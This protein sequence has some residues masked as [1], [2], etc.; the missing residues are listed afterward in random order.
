MHK[1]KFTINALAF[2]SFSLA[3]ASVAHAIPR[4]YVT[5]SGNDNNT[6]A[7]NAPC[8]TF[9]EAITKTDSGGE[10]IPLETGTYGLLTID[11]P[12]SIIAPPGVHAEIAPSGALTGIIVQGGAALG[13]VVLRNLYLTGTPNVGKGIDAKAVGALHVENCVIHGFDKGINFAPAPGLLYV[14]DTTVRNSH[15]GIYVVSTGGDNDN[16]VK[17][18][19]EHCRFENYFQGVVA[20]DRYGSFTIRDSIFT[21]RGRDSAVTYGGIIAAPNPGGSTSIMVE[22]CLLSN[23]HLAIGTKTDG[24]TFFYLSQNVIYD[25]QYGIS[26]CCLSKLNTFGN[27]RFEHND[28]DGFFNDSTALK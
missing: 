18:F 27:N 9:K 22:N 7:F 21:G 25:N 20:A 26:I 16:R 11:K 8:R 5:M 4:T 12:V 1:I 10:I 13:S 14:K 2:L 28:D 15:D 23:N 6:C 24:V 3:L 17:V 19:I